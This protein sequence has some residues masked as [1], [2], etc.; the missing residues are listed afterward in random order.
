MSSNSHETLR[1]IVLLFFLLTGATGPLPEAEPSPFHLGPK[2]ETAFLSS[3]A[4]IALTGLYFHETVEPPAPGS[5]DRNRVLRIDRCA[6]GNSSDAADLLSDVTMGA[7]VALPLLTSAGMHFGADIPDW[8]ALR[9]DLTMYFESALLAGGLTL[10]AKGLTE[11][12]RPFVYGPETPDRKL[13]EKDSARSFW[14]GHT[15]LA[16]NGAVFAGYVFQRRRPDSPLT[17][18]VWAGGLTLATVTAVMRVRAGEHFPTDVLAGA[19][20]G[21]LTGWFV[22]RMHRSDPKRV[23]IAPDGPGV[24]IEIRF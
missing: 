7:S 24:E 22:P 10:L 13:R 16:F 1:T 15:V 8:R 23:R 20:V 12:P 19:A 21:S 6:I 17:V 9:T 11:R 3:G 18:P 14:S 5:L 4:V 2:R